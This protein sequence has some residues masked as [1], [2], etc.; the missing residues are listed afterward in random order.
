MARAQPKPAQGAPMNSMQNNMAVRHHII[1][2][3]VEMTQPMQ[4]FS[5]TN[6]AL[7]IPNVFTFTP[8]NV[9][10]LRRMYVEVVLTF[11]TAAG[12]TSCVKTPH[13][14]SNIFSNIVFTD[15]QN[16]ARI[17][18]NGF[19]L[20]AVNSVKSKAAAPIGSAEVSDTPLG[21]GNNFSP[22]SAPATVA[23]STTATVKT[24]YEIPICYSDTDLRGS[25]YMATT[26][27]N[28]TLQLSLNQL[29]F[30]LTAS[31]DPTFAAYTYAGTAPTITSVLCTVTQDYLDQLPLMNGR[32]LLPEN[33]INTIYQLLQ[34]N[35]SGLAVNQPFGIPYTNLRSFLSTLVTFDNGGVLNAG[36][37]VVNIGLQSA[38]N[39]FIWQKD[40]QLIAYMTRKMI[41]SDMPVGSYYFDH[42]QRP[43]STAQFGNMQLVL[44]P[45]VVNANAQLILGYEFM[46][47]RKA[48]VGAASLPIG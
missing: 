46:A 5:L 28:A 48:V 11:Q 27:A 8:K 32:V 23:A 40:P 25:I 41:N 16:Q 29:F 44:T 45:S 15:F 43:I 4:T 30:G 18:T 33:D 12:T 19:H 3:S 22:V 6:P 36:T 34:T 13:G 7:N 42:R 37:D 35:V 2:N 39:T 47:A 24:V 9:G 21:F 20:S 1:A 38:N 10:L 17:S 31:A 26:G 14:A